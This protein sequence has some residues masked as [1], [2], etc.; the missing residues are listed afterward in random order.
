MAR[1][2]SQRYRSR[3]RRAG[4]LDIR[5]PGCLVLILF[6]LVGI[7]AIIHVLRSIPPQI[8]F[9]IFFLVGSVITAIIIS[10]TYRRRKREQEQIYQEQLYQEQIHQQWLYQEHVQREQQY[11]EQLHQEQ[12]RQ[13]RA[14]QENERLVRMNRLGDLLALTPRQFEELIGKLLEASGYQNV[15]RVGGSGD[16]GVD[17]VAYDTQGSYIVVQCKRYNPGKSVSS[18]DLQKFIGM[19][20]LHH[21]ADKGIFVTTSSFTR[22]AIDLAQQQSI[23]LVDGVQLVQWVQNFKAYYLLNTQIG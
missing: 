7:S 23:Q 3:K 19:M 9:I 21:K 20:V 16:L 11:Q 5:V 10:K 17:L 12:L 13:E 8:Y 14:H 15:R 22:P 2:R 4:G 1:R 6:G 18:P